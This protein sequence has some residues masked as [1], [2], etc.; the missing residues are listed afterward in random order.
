MYK[1]PLSCLSHN[2]ASLAYYTMHPCL[3]IACK[4]KTHPC[5]FIICGYVISLVETQI[6][7]HLCS[8]IGHVFPGR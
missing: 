7:C 1:W 3:V 4:L 6:N 2:I 8:D 5:V